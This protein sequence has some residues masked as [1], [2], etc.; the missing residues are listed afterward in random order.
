MRHLEGGPAGGVVGVEHRAVVEHHADVAH[1]VVRV[2]R[3]PAAHAGRVVGDDAADPARLDRGWVRSELPGIGSKHP[4]HLPEDPARL[5]GDLAAVVGDLPVP[6]RVPELQEDAVSDGLARERGP[7]RAE[8]DGR[9][10]LARGE[11]KLDHL[12]LIVNLDNDLGH[13]AVEGSVGAVGEGAQGVGE[14]ARV[15]DDRLDVLPECLVT[16]LQGLIAEGRPLLHTLG[17][18]PGSTA[19]LGRLVVDDEVDVGLGRLPLGRLRGERDVRGLQHRGSRG[20]LCG[21]RVL[22]VLGSGLQRPAPHRSR[23]SGAHDGP[24]HDWPF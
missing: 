20:C 14:D 18:E 12:L 1:G 8:G 15:G 10:V 5:D 6:P 21:L 7:P 11:D 4:V 19:V 24:L 23:A 17:L 3:H 13:E 22:L 16:P 9:L 2:L